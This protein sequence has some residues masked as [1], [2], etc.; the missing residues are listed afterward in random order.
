[1][2]G[3]LIATIVSSSV[4]VT[5]AIGGGFWKVWGKLGDQ[6]KAIGRLEGKMDGL[7]TRMHSYEKQMEGFDS[8][9]SRLDQRI[10]GFVDALMKKGSRKA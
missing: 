4:I 5:G 3:A 8:R 10:N 7:G 2:D 9:V 1:M 6:N